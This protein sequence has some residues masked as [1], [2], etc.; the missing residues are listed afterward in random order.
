TYVPPAGFPRSVFA[1]KASAFSPSPPGAIQSRTSV[2]LLSERVQRLVEA[3]RELGHLSVDLDP[4]GLVKR[5]GPA[6]ALKDYGL[7]EEDLDLVFSSENVAGPDRTTLRDLIGLL[8][9]TY[10]RKM[11]VELAHL[12]E[13][14][15]RSWLQSR[16][17]GTR[18]RVAL[19]RADRMRLLQQVIG[20]EVFEQF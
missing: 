7:V 6:H 9:E 12:H 1:A 4:L 15:L 11:G 10:S 5:T 17:E 19:S 20:A 14:E 8:Q 18:N 16:M 2:R 13:V 3:Y